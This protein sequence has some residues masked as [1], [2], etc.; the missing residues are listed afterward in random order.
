MAAVVVRGAAAQQQLQVFAK[1]ARKQRQPLAARLRQRHRLLD[2]VSPIAQAAQVVNDDHAGVAQHVVH[3]HIDRRRLAQKHQIDQPH[4]RKIRRQLRRRVR[5]QRQR[6]VGG[7][8]DDD[9][10]GRLLYAHHA[11]ATVL[12]MAT[13]ARR[14]Q[15]HHRPFLYVKNNSC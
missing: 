10:A 5:Q 15:M 13:G 6:G 7:A 12:H 2:D 11:L 4:R 3:I 8:Q 1:V 14:K 9:V